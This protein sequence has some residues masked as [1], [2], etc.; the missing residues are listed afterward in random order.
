M[1]FRLCV[2]ILVGLLTAVNPLRVVAADRAFITD[3]RAYPEDG[4]LKL[5]LRI[6]NCFTPEM[7]D[8]IKSGVVTTFKIL[9][10]IDSPGL[11]PFRSKVLDTHLEHSLKYDQLTD[12]Y[13]VTLDEHPKEVLTTSDFDKARR[14]MSQV[15]DISI[16]PLWRLGRSQDY[17]LRIK[18]ELSKVRLPTPLRYLFFFVSLWDFETDWVVM[19]LKY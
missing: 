16:L 7:V 10:T 13:H 2:W 8:A 9:I 15:R 3:C 17:K 14:A 1:V 11:P 12:E 6:E 4:D 5:S 19:D 18:A